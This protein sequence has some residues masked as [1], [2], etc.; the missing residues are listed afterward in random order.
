MVNII[1][2]PMAKYSSQVHSTSD[3][4]KFK[5]LSGNRKV[6]ELHL[7]RLI[8]S[9]E[10]NYLFSPITIN[11]NWEII[12]G[13]H[14]F[15]AAK[16]LGLPI[17]Y[18]MVFGYSLPEVQILNSNT[19]NWNKNDYLEAYCDLGYKPYLIMNKFMQD[20][21]MFALTTCEALLR[22]RSGEYYN[23]R[24]KGFE[25]GDL[26]ID[27]LPLSYENAKKILM[28]KPYYVGYHRHIFVLTLISLFKNPNYNHLEMIN[29]IKYQSS[30]LVH[31]S[32]RHQYLSI[33]E[34]IYNFKRRDK[35]SLRY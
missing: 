1:A 13:Q 16:N 7:K 25:M 30:L 31:C 26:V 6:N 10:K 14:R 3:Y 32:L 9:F 23:D 11:E 35:V 20:F 19:S 27:N 8:K 34:E 4:S 15:F 18:I 28:F 21:P 29:K 33:L 5:I 17:F 2:E 12:D 24:S 22:N